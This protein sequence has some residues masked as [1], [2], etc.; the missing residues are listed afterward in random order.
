MKKENRIGFIDGTAL[1]I[2]AMISMVFDHVGDMFMPDVMW[3]RMIGRIAMPIFCFFIAEGYIHTRDKKK[4]LLRLGIFA[5]IS[6]VPFDLAFEGRL[7]LSHQN[8]ML[9]FFIAV[10]ALMVFDL[11]RGDINPDTGK[12]G[13]LRTFSAQSSI[14]LF[15]VI[16]L[17]LKADYSVFAVMA[18]YLFYIL[19]E[20]N[21]ILRSAVGVGF[22]AITRTMGYY[23]A[24]GLS[25][26]PLCLYN[27]KRGKGFKW[28][29]Y[30]F[31]PGHLL[32]LYIIKLYVFGY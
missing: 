23:S 15:A 11:I 16:A 27:G 4:Y 32:L 12:Y 8:I 3:L 19:S 30:I 29:F 13:K 25:L 1:K 2:I 10:S 5:L 17:L 21:H 26:I 9:T 18:V 24:T 22:L 7:N 14:L 31:Y 28:L 6:E 20:S